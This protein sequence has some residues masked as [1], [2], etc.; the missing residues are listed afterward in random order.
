MKRMS[1]Q[2][3]KSALSAAIAEAESGETILI[4]RHAAAVAQLGPAR[5]ASIHRS[6]RT[7]LKPLRPAL[8]RPT[9]GRYLTVLLEDRGEQ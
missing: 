9:R 5:P 8:K 7:G 6:S 1:I 3:L 4:T 2:G